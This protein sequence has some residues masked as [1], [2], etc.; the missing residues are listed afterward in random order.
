MKTFSRIQ[1]VFLSFILLFITTTQNSWAEIDSITPPPGAIQVTPEEFQALKKDEVQDPKKESSNNLAGEFARGGLNGGGGDAA[2]V[3]FAIVGAVMLIAWIPYVALLT[4]RGIKNPEL[5]KFNYLFST[6]FMNVE[7]RD[8]LKQ[9]RLGEMYSVRFTSIASHKREEP[10][11][12]NDPLDKNYGLNFEVG[13]YNF[14]DQIK[15]NGQKLKYHG[16]YWLIGPSFIL[17]NLN[18][19]DQAFPL[20]FKVDLTAGTSFHQEIDLIL[21]GELTINLQTERGF[22]IGAGVSGLYLYGRE[23]KG[24]ISHVSDLSVQGVMTTGWIF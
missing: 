7:E 2:V 11:Q 14:Y 21:R 23:G 18:E 17:G 24:I 3:I 13:Y 15:G 20:F 4:Y 16:P 1:S 10:R 8:D 19:M 22:F 5:Y 9:R 6:Q 12:S